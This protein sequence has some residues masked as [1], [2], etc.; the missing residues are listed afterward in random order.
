[1]K[2]LGSICVLLG[3]IGVFLP[4][5][6]TTPFLLL[7]MFFFSKSNPELGRKLLNNKL[8]GGYIRS[9]TSGLGMP[10]R[11]KVRII[12]LLWLVISISAYFTTD[13]IYVRIVLGLIALLVS[14]HIILIRPRKVKSPPT[15]HE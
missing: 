13:N 12:A 1:M 11:E 4:L 7:A 5:M 3:F 10:V 6:P 14:V 9:Y 15:D 2:I 8:L